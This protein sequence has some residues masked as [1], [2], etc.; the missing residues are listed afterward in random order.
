MTRIAIIDIGK[1]NAKLALVDLEARA[2]IAVVKTPNRVL[3]GPP[4]PHFDLDGL[5]SFLS[6]AMR[7]FHAEHGIDAIGI[8]T[9]GASAVLLDETGAL[10]VPMLDYEFDGP[11]A[12]GP[13]YD[14]LRPDFAVT[15]SPRLPLGLN[16]GA[17]LHWLLR[18]Q[19]GL[20]GRVARVVT[21]PQY[22]AGRLT[23][24]WATEVTSLGCHTDLWEPRAG[25]FSPLVE[26]LGLA[27]KMAPVHLAGDRLGTLSP[28]VAAE[29]GL[30]AETPVYCGIHDSNASLYPHLLDQPLPF[31]V[32][33]TGTWVIA[34]AMGGA[35]VPLDPA[36]DTLIN[37]NALGAPVPSAR[38]MGGREFEMLSG[39]SAA[40]PAANDI[41]FVLDAGHA[42]LPA[43]VPESGP[44]R[45]R[46]SR[47]TTPPERL[48]PGQH[49][50]VISLYLALMAG[51]CLQMIGAQGPVLTE[52]PFAR[53][54]LFLDMLGAL[55]GRAILL[56]GGSAT[57]TSIGAALLALPQGAATGAAPAAEHPPADAALH[58]KLTR[59]AA[60]WR[61][62]LEE[63]DLIP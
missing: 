3:A 30:P 46:R 50:A 58:A 63:E 14:A 33:S 31:S 60:R 39:G 11:E 55:T 43:V 22:W 5:W 38:F 62:L 57:G 7:R 23:G 42:L 17:Q 49:A 27:D 56:P 32:L 12:L 20:S 29:L 15:G 40:Q 16:L 41:A 1:T 10:A 26:K 4:Y 24:R 35:P 28:D 21:Y 13:D 52:G 44:F 61:A 34:M 45:G 8:T 37:V 53:N 59:Y 51:T 9:H 47:W 18:T 6:G 48:T 2:E 19:P 36:R 54:A 25:R